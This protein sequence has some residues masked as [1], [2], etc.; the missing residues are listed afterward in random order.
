MIE[1]QGLKKSYGSKLVLDGVHLTV[2][3]GAKFG[4][5]GINGAGKSTLLRLI[6]DVLRPDE[7]SILLDGE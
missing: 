4:L 1:I 3:D 7:G 5:V 2:P 6:A